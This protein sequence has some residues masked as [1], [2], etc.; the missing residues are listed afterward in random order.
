MKKLLALSAIALLAACSQSHHQHKC[1]QHH[2]GYDAH[3]KNPVL[4]QAMKDCHS[5]I[6]DK[7]DMVEFEKCL[8]DKGFEKPANHLKVKGHY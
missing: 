1:H 3:S 8:K 7:K 6:K 4:T 5:T 2:H